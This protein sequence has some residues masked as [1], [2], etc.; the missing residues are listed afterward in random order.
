MDEEDDF[1]AL[2]PRGAQ[3]MLGQ[4][5]KQYMG[6][7]ERETQLR[8]QAEQSRAQRFRQA[9]E[10]IR[11]ARLGP[12]VAE[13]MFGLSAAFLAPKPYRGV[14]GTMANLVPTLGAMAGARGDA[15][16]KRAEML[17]KLEADYAAGRETLDLEAVERERKGLADLMR[18]YGPLS[19]TP[20]A[21]T[22][23]S[24]VDGRV[25]DLDTGEEVVP[26]SSVPQGAID[27][28]RAYVQNP[29]NSPENRKIAMQNFERKFRV[30]AQKALEGDR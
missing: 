9:Q 19:K 13:Q 15:E 5:T 12:S 28:L 4:L 21:R 11:A 24:P 22:Q 16:S 29:A 1:A 10:K 14:A 8:Q 6:L 27:Q 23:I 7:G 30:S 20:R 17:A 26:L 25:Y 18:V 2:D 3:D